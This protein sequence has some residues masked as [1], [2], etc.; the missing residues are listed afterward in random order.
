MARFI[1]SG[2]SIELPANRISQ[3]KSDE[4]CWRGGAFVTIRFNRE[5]HEAIRVHTGGRGFPDRSASPLEG[6]WV[7]IGDV[8][9]TSGQIVDSRSLPGEFTRVANAVIPIGC[10]AN[11]GVASSLLA[12]F[13]GG[14]QAEYV[15]GPVFQ[16]KPIQNKSWHGRAGFA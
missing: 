6:K 3:A 11:I 16:F 4:A 9:M 7:L 15:S 2:K 10:L 12:G 8:I 5:F 1:I 14:L 13:G